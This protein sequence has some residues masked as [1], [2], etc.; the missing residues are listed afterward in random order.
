MQ[1]LQL[2]TR[3]STHTK[4]CIG[5]LCLLL[6]SQKSEAQ[7]F[8]KD[9][10]NV[11]SPKK[12]AIRSAILPGWGQHYNNK[13]WKMPVI[14][15]GMGVSTGF[16]VFNSYHY[17]R[18]NKLYKIVGPTAQNV[19]YGGVDYTA[20]DVYAYKNYYRRN[21]DLSVISLVIIYALNI[22]D[23]NVDGHL[24]DFNVSD[25]LKAD[26]QPILQ[27]DPYGKPIAGLRLQ[28]SLH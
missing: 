19:N 23:A 20:N 4:L 26:L 6:S 13:K 18:Y 25:D 28:L 12:A 16:I 24:Y 22:I 7:I 2:H 9:S 27:P 21:L 15:A 8:R 17:S 10:T 5:I 1:I 3:L 11:H 14:Y